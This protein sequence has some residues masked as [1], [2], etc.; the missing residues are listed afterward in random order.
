MSLSEQ[1]LETLSSIAQQLRDEGGGRALIDLALSLTKGQYRNADESYLGAMQLMAG[2][3]AE[4]MMDSP[5]R[6][7]CCILHE[8][9]FVQDMLQCVALHYSRVHAERMD[10]EGGA[11]GTA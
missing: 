4:L 2:A 5:T 10:K 1:E 7:K 6:P 9:S 11:D 3:Y 8:M